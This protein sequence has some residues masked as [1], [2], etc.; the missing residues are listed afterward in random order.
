MF[1]SPIGSYPLFSELQIYSSSKQNPRL[2]IFQTNLFI[3]D[4]RL[5]SPDVVQQ[6]QFVLLS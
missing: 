1:M 5:K 2:I 6:N 4:P 3:L